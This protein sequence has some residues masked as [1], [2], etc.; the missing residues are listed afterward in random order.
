[1]AAVLRLVYAGYLYMGTDMWSSKKHATDVIR[2]TVLGLLILLAIY[3]V[4]YQINP[5][6]L[7]LNVVLTDIKSS[8]IQP[9]ATA[10]EPQTNPLLG[11]VGGQT[12]IQKDTSTGICYLNNL[13]TGEQEVISCP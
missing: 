2:D 9:A 8:P 10:P 7:N 13:S 5:Q 3:L 6:I 4:L 12:T 1:M 11:G